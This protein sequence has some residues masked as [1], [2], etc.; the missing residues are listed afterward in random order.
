MVRQQSAGILKGTLGTLILKALSW[1]PLN[2]FEVTLWLERQSAGALDIDDSA[3]YQALHR[4]EE[5]GLVTGEWAL[6]EKNRRARYYRLTTAGRAELRAQSAQL[7]AYARA[8][9][10]ILT[11]ARPA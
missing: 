3:L 4:L 1:Q 7:L 9:T 2:G 5:R 11:S 8:M 6:S 10:T